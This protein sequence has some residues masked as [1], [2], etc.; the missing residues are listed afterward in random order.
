MV[1][2]VANLAVSI[3]SLKEVAE[4]PACAIVRRLD[5]DELALAL[6]S[7]TSQ[8]ELRAAEAASR[9]R[10]RALEQ[11]A[12]ILFQNSP[13]A[14]L[15]MDARSGRIRAFNQRAFEAFGYTRNELFSMPFRFLFPESA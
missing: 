15:V 11:K 7:V 6:L 9:E 13:N 4:S 2:L 14:M 12:D 3:K 5:A 10:V 8:M 1:V